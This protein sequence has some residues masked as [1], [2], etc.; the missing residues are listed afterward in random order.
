M[1]QRPLLFIVGAMVIL[2][3]LFELLRPL[4]P[5]GAK[6]AHAATTTAATAAPA[7][8]AVSVPPTVQSSPAAASAETTASQ[9]AAAVKTFVIEVR[10]GQRISGPERIESHEGDHVA[11]TVT[12]D[13]PDEMHLHGY[14][15]HLSLRANEPATLT[16]DATHSGR[17]DYEL[18][19]A[20]TTLGT[21]EVL[22][23]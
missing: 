4:P 9:P 1:L 22:P 13:Q 6:H 23:Q 16:F 15:L 20:H 14:D 18:H 7:A 21:L 8:S 11:L 17:F 10:N 3:G 2:T 12:S 5:G 19:H